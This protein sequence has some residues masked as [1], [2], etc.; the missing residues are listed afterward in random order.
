MAYKTIRKAAAM[1]RSSRSFRP[2]REVAHGI[3]EERIAHPAAVRTG[4]VDGESHEFLL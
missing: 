4:I 2:V 1:G 3:Y